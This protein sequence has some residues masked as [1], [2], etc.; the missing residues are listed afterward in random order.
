MNPTRFNVILVKFFERDREEN[1]VATE[2]V[3]GPDDDF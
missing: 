3:R 1:R 2:P